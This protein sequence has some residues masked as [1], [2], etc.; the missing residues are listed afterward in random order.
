MDTRRSR[1]LA[2]WAVLLVL[3]AWASAAAAA[4]GGKRRRPPPIVSLGKVVAREVRNRL[5]AVGTVAPYRT[6]I[7]SSEI[8]GIVKT[9]PLQEGDPVEA[10]KTVIATLSRTDLEHDIRVMAAELAKARQDHLRLKRGSRKEVIAALRAKMRERK[11]RRQRD[12]LELK[13]AEDLYNRKVLDKASYDLAV[14]NYEGSK[15]LADEAKSNLREAEIGPRVEEISKAAAEVNR[16]RALIARVRDKLSKAV[17]RSP[18]TGFLTEKWAEVGQWVPKGGRVGEVVELSRVLVRAPISERR[19]AHVRVGDAAQV[20]LDALPG[21]TFTGRVRKIIP[22]ADPKSRTFPVEI[23]LE[24][25][26]DFAIKAGM[27]ARI[28]TKYGPAVRALLVPK[29]AILQRARGAAVFVFDKGKVRE[30]GFKRGRSVDSFVEIP[31]GTLAAGT[32]VVVQG[33][34]KLR[35]GMK[36]RL[37][38]SGRRGGKP[39]AGRKPGVGSKPSAGADGKPRGGR[40]G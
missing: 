27:F 18:F 20:I 40:R 19:I 32:K 3:L 16:V 38:G 28:T 6:S 30:V 39:G 26:P 2:R 34:E 9:F 4:P 1:F 37:R 21:R 31:P 5:T 23:E 29:D 14:A 10:G 11:A 8:E 7:V 35:S 25:T 33:N 15:S 36:V 22:K 12:A 13:R 17:I 24:N